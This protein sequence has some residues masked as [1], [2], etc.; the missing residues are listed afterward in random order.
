MRLNKKKKTKVTVYSKTNLFIKIDNAHIEQVQYFNYLGSKI[1]GDGWNK[2]DI[3][4]RLAQASRIKKH[5]LTIS[6]V[7]L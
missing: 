2:A 4:N 3:V 5:L 1:T 6:S 7:T